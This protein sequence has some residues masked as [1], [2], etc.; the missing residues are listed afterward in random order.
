MIEPAVCDFNSF[1]LSDVDNFEYLCPHKKDT[2]SD[3]NNNGRSFIVDVPTLSD[4]QPT[5]TD[6]ET[7]KTYLQENVH[8]EVEAD[9]QL[10]LPKMETVVHVAKKTKAEVESDSSCKARS[11]PYVR[12][13]I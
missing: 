13:R 11:R 9:T 4:D 3:K 8:A 2:V 6:G 7:V 5:I 12:V 1:L 10:K